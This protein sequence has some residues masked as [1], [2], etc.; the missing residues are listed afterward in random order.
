MKGGSQGGRKTTLISQAEFGLGGWILV[1]QLL[2]VLGIGLIFVQTQLEFIIKR[3]TS[4]RKLLLDKVPP[5]VLQGMWFNQWQWVTWKEVE[6]S[7][8]Q[9]EKWRAGGKETLNEHTF[10]VLYCVSPIAHLLSLYL[11]SNHLNTFITNSNKFR[12]YL[13]V[14]PKITVIFRLTIS[15]R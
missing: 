13:S 3:K 5:V 14:G 6:E 8:I 7:V 9:K 15:L 4:N 10:L 12:T 2:G 11:P 1:S